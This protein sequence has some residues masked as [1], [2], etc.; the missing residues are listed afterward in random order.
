MG[1]FRGGKKSEMARLRTEMEGK[2]K[3]LLQQK[4]LDPRRVFGRQRH[5]S[6]AKSSSG[7]LIL[8]LIKIIVYHSGYLRT[9]HLSNYGMSYPSMCTVCKCLALR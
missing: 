8:L 1:C 5:C 3:A 4:L 6:Y 7:L 9:P 2:M